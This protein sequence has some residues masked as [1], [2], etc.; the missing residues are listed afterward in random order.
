VTDSKQDANFIHTSN[1]GIIW[2]SVPSPHLKG[3][4]QGF[5]CFCNCQEWQMMSNT[6]NFPVFSG[7]NALS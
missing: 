4:I 3:K 6:Q 7:I 1:P 5:I 2:T